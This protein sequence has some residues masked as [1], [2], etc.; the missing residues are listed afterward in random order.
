MAKP[1]QKQESNTSLKGTIWLAVLAA[2]LL[3]ITNSAIWLNNQIFDTENFSKTATASLTSEKSRTAIATGLT[4]RAF[5]GRPIL[6]NVVGDVPVKI[7]GGLLGTEQAA[8][9]IDKVTSKQFKDGLSGVY[10]YF[11]AKVFEKHKKTILTF[12]GD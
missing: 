12:L 3:I 9:G 2:I 11:D 7:V 1:T 5:E 4:D 10:G 6:R 8:K